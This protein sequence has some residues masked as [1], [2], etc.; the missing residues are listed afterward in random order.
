MGTRYSDFTT[1]SN[2][3][4]A[5]PGAGFVN[6]NIAAFDAAKHTQ[7]PVICDAR[8]GL[9]AL[10]A[11]TSAEAQPDRSEWGQAG[12]DAKRTWDVAVDH[13]LRPAQNS[14]E[15]P[16]QPELLGTIA[17]ALGPRDAIVAA[18]GSLPSPPPPFSRLINVPGQYS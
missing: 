13:A 14:A 10:I 3:L 1:A 9:D 7:L 2:S 6:L 8:A 18:A 17:E 4:F 11:H 15:R 5:D 12:R 16:G